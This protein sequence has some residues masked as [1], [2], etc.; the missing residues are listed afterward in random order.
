MARGSAAVA[1][2][3]LAG[4][5]LMSACSNGGT[6][7]AQQACVHIDTSIRLFTRAEHETNRA[8]AARD[9]QKATA[10]LEQAEPLAARANDADP[11]FNPLMTTLQEVGRTSES[12]LIPALTAQCDAA[13]NPTALVPAPSGPTPSPGQPPRGS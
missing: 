3:L 11:A 2:L 7:L 9:A 4:G 5:V 12:N 6:S 10:E 1:G 13:N 8:V